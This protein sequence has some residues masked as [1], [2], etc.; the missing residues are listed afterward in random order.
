MCSQKGHRLPRCCWQL[1]GSSLIRAYLAQAES[2][3]ATGCKP[4]HREA[5]DY[6]AEL[7]RRD[8]EL[9][10]AVDFLVG[11]PGLDDAGNDPNP[12]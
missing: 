8:A 2:C 1:T 4:C 9:K 3:A 5:R 7:A 12:R 11:K 10:T 6:R